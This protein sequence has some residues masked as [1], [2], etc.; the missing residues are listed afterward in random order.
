MSVIHYEEINGTIGII[1]LNRPNAANALSNHLLQNFHDVLD[2]LNTNQQLRVIIIT[3]TGEKAFCAGADLKERRNMN[4]QDVKNAVQFIHETANRIAAINIPVIA[5]I[6]GAAYGGGLEF[7]LACDI[8]IM[9]EHAS[10][11]LTETSLAIIPGA[12]GTQR[13]SRLIGIGKA[14][15]LIYRA[16]RISAEEAFQLGIV[17]EI[18]EASSLKQTAITY[19]K[20]IAANG[21]LAVQ[22]AKT[23]INKGIEL[24]LDEALQLETELYLETIDT[25]D[26]KEGLIAF[27]EKRKPIYIGK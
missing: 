10:V 21:P 20:Q 19:A 17:E 11:G 23:A 12:G 24:P 14:K 7:A 26:R 27:S 3:A 9:A 25:E 15:H 16:A 2:D 1:I 8:R 5:A 22:L 18:V 4:E 6:N 13:L